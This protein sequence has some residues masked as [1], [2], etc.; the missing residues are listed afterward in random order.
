MFISQPSSQAAALTAARPQ[1]QAMA[2]SVVLLAIGSSLWLCLPDTR[3][4]HAQL[5]W[6]P[7]WTIVSPALCVAVQM[8]RLRGRAAW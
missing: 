7:L 4:F 5:G 3:G 8:L 6:L 1:A 2:A